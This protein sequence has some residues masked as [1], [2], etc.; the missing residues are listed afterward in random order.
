MSSFK[1]TICILLTLLLFLCTACS[2]DSGDTV[3][4]NDVNSNG[5][6]MSSEV[7]PSASDNNNS[8][9]LITEISPRLDLWRQVPLVNK[10]A[11][12]MGFDGGE[13]CQW[14]T[15]ITFDEIDGSV[16]FCSVDVGGL[17]RSTDGGMNWDQ[18]T[19]GIRSEGTTGV[20]IDPTNNNRVACIGTYSNHSGFYGGLHFSTDKGET[21]T[22]REDTKLYIKNAHDFRRQI[23]F[24]K[25]S[26]DA[27]ING[28]RDIYWVTNT[29]EKSNGYGG[30]YKSTDGGVNWSLITGSAR[31]EYSNIV[32]HP[33]NGD[34]YISNSEGLFKSTDGAEN[35]TCVYKTKINYIATS[36]SAPNN[37]YFTTDNELFVYNTVSGEV[38][39]LNKKGYPSEYANYL[40]VSPSDPNRMTVAWDKV[41]LGNSGGQL[42]LY[43]NDGGATWTMSESDYTGSF[44]P[45]QSRENTT[46]FHPTDPNIILK[47]G[48][49][50]IMRST[51]GG[52]RYVMSNDGYNGMAIG[53]DFN[54]NINN[55]NLVSVS[56]QD[57][58]G[59]FSTD[60]GYTWTYLCW[61]EKGWGGFTYGSYMI[62]ET[63]VV[64]SL[65][66]SWTSERELVVTYDA[67]K[68]ITH[69]GLYIGSLT[70]GIGIKGD[71]NIAFFSNY[72]T[73]DA[74]R[75]WS[76]MNGCDG[77]YT[78]NSDGTVL[79]GQRGKDTVVISRDKGETWTALATLDISNGKTIEDIAYN[80][81]T[82][83][84]YIPTYDNLFTVSLDTGEWS[85][86]PWAG[87]KSVAVDPTDNNIM[88][89]AVRNYS[90]YAADSAMRSTDGGKT[91]HCINRATGDGE[92]GPDG[93]RAANYVRVDGNG[94]AWFIGHCR[95][96]WAIA[97]P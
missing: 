49:D 48:G 65:G 80:N 61:S 44:I 15:G 23:A 37:I 79:F 60:G 3:L 32:V 91:W 29:H 1:R 52:A 24:S 90:N 22:Y 17:L 46:S 92:N 9:N 66:S 34:V 72:R 14:L 57:Y 13:G 75:T 25:S 6:D 35:F 18:Y 82:R 94:N 76:E 71:G 33:I 84:V 12:D 88:Y 93:G 62:N 58:N 11:R 53:G 64:A 95:G 42:N 19:V 4:S 51:D 47:L 68:S 70:T 55:S 31:W 8:D 63:T 56:S 81:N 38:T 83:T 59:G 36:K 73:T 69:T 28:C 54:F 5:F 85:K 43:S 20:A 40:S 7:Q 26:Y 67:G 16:A 78:S 50:F 2:G 21:W 96:L 89:A 87:I 10:Q 30:I 41:G 27:A 86:N 77:V 45:Y 74:G 39:K 97:K